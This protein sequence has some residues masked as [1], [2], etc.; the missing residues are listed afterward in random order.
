MANKFRGAAIFI[1]IIM[2][3]FGNFGVIAQPPH[4]DGEEKTETITFNGYCDEGSSWEKAIELGDISLL[5]IIFL[6]TWQD[7][8]GSDSDPD[9]LSLSADDGMNEISGQA[10]TGS[11]SVGSDENGL[12]DSWNAVVTCESAGD[13]PLFRSGGF[14]TEDDPGNSWT[15]EVTYTYTEGMGGPPPEVARMLQVIQTPQF[16]VHVALMIASVFLFL[17]TG[18]FAGIFLYSRIKWPDLKTQSPLVRKLFVIPFFLILL[19]IVTFIIF[20]LASVPFGMWVASDMYG[21]AKM[22]TGFPAIWNTEAFDMTN[23]DNVSF[24]VLLFWF[25]PMYINRAQIMRSK[26]F[27]KLFGKIKFAMKRAEKAPDPIIPN[28]VLALCYCLL[29]IMTF[30]IFEVQ[31]HGSGS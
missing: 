26:Y 8:E 6:L 18:L 1:I 24:I 16:K 25:I 9:T 28:G 19:V 3:T 13:T 22:W 7:D 14:L 17:G 10:N 27:K 21:P 4:G 31:P 30:V 20:F 29:G 2:I 15:L 12:N 5:E 11:L 23:A